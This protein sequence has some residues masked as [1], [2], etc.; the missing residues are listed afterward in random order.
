MNTSKV[1]IKPLKQ[2][3]DSGMICDWETGICGPITENQLSSN[4]KNLPIE[5]MSL[6]IFEYDVVDDADANK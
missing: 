4:K 2:L 6:H 1:K 3:G 5:S